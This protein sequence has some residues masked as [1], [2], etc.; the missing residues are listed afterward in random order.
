MTTK[1]QRSAAL[2]TAISRMGGAYKAARI[3]GI[4]YQA[5]YNWHRVPAKHVAAVSLL[6]NMALDQLRPDFLEPP[7]EALEGYPPETRAALKRAQT[8]RLEAGAA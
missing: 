5:I 3:L 8:A 6:A 2:Q 4:S 7:A 1:A